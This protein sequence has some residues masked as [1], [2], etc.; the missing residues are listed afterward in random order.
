MV[1]ARPT[2]L[3]NSSINGDGVHLKIR[4][5]PSAPEQKAIIEANFGMQDR[6]I[7]I[8]TRFALVGHVLQRYQIE[9]KKLE[10]KASARQIV[11]K[12]L[13]ALKLAL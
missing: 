11:L 9:P 6:E 8:P 5:Q 2:Q 1:T 7:V 10:P 4:G 13:E 12:N 3:P